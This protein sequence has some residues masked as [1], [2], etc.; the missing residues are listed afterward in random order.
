MSGN[1]IKD[2]ARIAH[3]SVGT[4]SMALNGKPGVNEETRERVLEIAR[5]LNYKPNPY[6][7]FLTCKKTNII[8]LIVTDITNPFFGN[9]INYIQQMLGEN[10]YDI[11]LGISRGSIKEEKKIVQKFIDMQVDGVIA[12]PSHNPTPDT[13]HYEKLQ[14][15]KIPVCFIT[16]Y[17]PNIH[18]SCIMTDLSD[19]AYQL[20]KYLLENGHR[21]IIYLVGDLSVPVSNLR[22][23][24]Y[25]SAYRN[26][27][28]SHEPNWIVTTNVTLQG[29]YDATKLI[30]ECFHPHAII[31]ANDFMAMGVLKCLKEHN[32]RV[33]QDIS[34]AGYDDLIYSS[35]LETP[36]T[37]VHQPLEQICQRTVS[38]FLKQLNN[39]EILT[40][41]V[42][43]KPTLIIRSSSCPR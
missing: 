29:G 3:V 24:G 27:G 20:T 22:A 39:P 10:G 34:V 12:V 21:R 18:A 14:K 33:P 38:I 36:L 16:S 8:G 40:E 7:R 6:A 43:L 31:T 35:M 2:V 11:M 15:L 25:T 23:E 30:L 37:T 26:A 5:Q 28:L 9:M 17:Y 4:A 19:G 41:K 13:L 32:L 42:L 1:T